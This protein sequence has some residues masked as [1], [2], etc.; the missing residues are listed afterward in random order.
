MLR[1]KELGGMVGSGVQILCS[2]YCTLFRFLRGRAEEGTDLIYNPSVMPM[3]AGRLSDLE[4]PLAKRVA[5]QSTGSGQNRG[6]S[7]NLVLVSVTNI[8]NG[9]LRDSTVDRR[10]RLPPK[11]SERESRAHN[12]K[13]ACASI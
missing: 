6:Y 1:K 5:R 8:V 3:H 11:G 7:R 2:R 9:N 10:G 4:V 12:H 13:C